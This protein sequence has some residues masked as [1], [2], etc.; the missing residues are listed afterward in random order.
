MRYVPLEDLW[1]IHGLVSVVLACLQDAGFHPVI[2]CDS[3]GW[4]HFRGWPL[5][6]QR[7]VTIWI[8]QA[9]RDEALAFLS[10]P[11]ELEEL[12]ESRSTGFWSLLS[13]NRPLV[14]VAWGLMLFCF[15][16]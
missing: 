16:T 2:E 9:E 4:L 7:P 10:S 11:F 14:F 8:P 13:R 1:P 3:R 5:G 12:D 6:S 15:A